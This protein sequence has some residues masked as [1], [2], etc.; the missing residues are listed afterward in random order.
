M[1]NWFLWMIAGVLSLLAGVLALANPL[2]ATLTAELLAG[3]G[4]VLVGIITLFS[5]FGDQSWGARLVAILLGLAIL[6]LGINLVAHPLR[7]IISLTLAAAIILLFAG[8]FRLVLGFVVRHAQ[9]RWAMILSGALSIILAIMIFANFPRSAVVVLGLLLAIE[10][11][12]NGVSLIALS[13]A[14]KSET[15]QQGT[16]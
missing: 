7:G 5:A 15:T 2:A 16:T 10:L 14:R 9:L 6:L 3:W 12:S 11:I 1:G 8:V 4:F 13:L